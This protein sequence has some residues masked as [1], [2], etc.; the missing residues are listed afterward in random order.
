[1][2]KRKLMRAMDRYH[3]LYR[4]Y[5]HEL[6]GLNIPTTANLHWMI[7]NGFSD[8]EIQQQLGLPW[9]TVKV[10]REAYQYKFFM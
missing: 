1:M 9:T 2:K 8:Q 5:L 10:F 3:R 6:K 4:R 7:R